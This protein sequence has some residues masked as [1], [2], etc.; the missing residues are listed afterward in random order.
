[1]FHIENYICGKIRIVCRVKN[2]KIQEG[3][4][5]HKNLNKG[6]SNNYVISTALDLNKGKEPTYLSLFIWNIPQF[7]RMAISKI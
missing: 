4:K 2:V 5:T 6:E 1:M 7:L 3:A